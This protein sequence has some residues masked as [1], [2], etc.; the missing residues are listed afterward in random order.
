MSVYISF[1]NVEIII[2]PQ[3]A[4]TVSAYRDEAPAGGTRVEGVS[5]EQG[6][7]DSDM[8]PEDYHVYGD[9]VQVSPIQSMRYNID[10]MLTR[11]A[12]PKHRIN[13][14]TRSLHHILGRRLQSR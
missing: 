3:V 9:I 5:E 1:F 14:A 8:L 10:L 13:N 2:L 12:H 4:K 7:S 6:G 11:T